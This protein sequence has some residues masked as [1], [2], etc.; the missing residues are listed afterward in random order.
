MKTN[1]LKNALFVIL[2]IFLLVCALYLG[3]EWSN[4]HNIIPKFLFKLPT[5]SVA[6]D[7]FGR[8]LSIFVVFGTIFYTLAALK[9]G[10]VNFINARR[11]IQE[12]FTTLFA[13]T[14]CTLYIFFATDLPFSPDFFAGTG[15]VYFALLICTQFVFDFFRKKLPSV[16]SGLILLKNL[17]LHLLKTTL[18]VG[19]IF[20]LIFAMSPLILMKAYTSNKDVANIV[21]QIRLSLNQEDYEGWLLVSAVPDLTFRQP[22]MAQFSPNNSDDI[23]ILERHGRIYK[24]DYALGG[25]KI[26]MLDFSGRVGDADMENGALGFD[27]H[28]QFDQD[29]SENS[30]YIYIYY[31]DFTDIA[32]GTQTNRLSRFN[33]N[34][35]SLEK[36]LSSEYP[37]IEFDRLNDG[38]HNGGSVEF[39]PDNFLYIAIG[40]SSDR[41][42][43]QKINYKLHGGILR[44]DV[45]QTGGDISHPI[46]RQALDTTS[47]GYFIPSDNPFVGQ[48]NVLEE[49]WALGLRNPFRISFDIKT[50]KLWAGDVGSTK[51][52]E[53]NIIEKGGNY[54]FPYIEGITASIGEKPEDFVGVEKGPAYFYTHTAYERS[55]IGGVVYRYAKNS[56][57]TGKY[58]FMDNY[59]GKI[60]TL[61]ADAQE[62]IDPITLTRSEQVAQRGITSLI[63][64]PNGDILLT[65]LG[66][67]QDQSGR[68]MKLVPSSK[69]AIAARAEQ[70]D[71]QQSSHSHGNETVDALELYKVNCARCHGATGK[72]DGPDKEYLE[73]LIPDFTNGDFTAARS[74]EFWFRVIKN[75]GEEEGLGTEMPMWEGIL[76]DN[77]MNEIIKLLRS[78]SETPQKTSQETN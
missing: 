69:E 67:S 58:I 28:P 74:D 49:F 14:T 39:G 37:L 55:I 60:Y 30:G 47:Q 41:K 66:R 22:I 70:Q 32:D 75:G 25:E 9:L 36:R 38:Y 51:F 50:G 21:T 8:V 40:E 46:P 7:T 73:S 42:G 2:Q 53:L 24:V 13:F 23:Y 33:L 71:M 76:E 57:L 56:E 54:Q 27:L 43:H 1:Y 64:A 63:A 17:G 10:P 5:V 62:L 78:F 31:T 72:G 45:D 44:I 59:S 4:S 68:L 65:T 52:E 26:L 19:G 34:E 6:P 48:D 18:S 11:T 15:L 3:K 61:D 20:V 35:D 16:I 77:E 12:L 29:A